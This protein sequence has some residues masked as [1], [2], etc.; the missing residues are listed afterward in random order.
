MPANVPDAYEYDENVRAAVINY[1][2]R[3]GLQPTGKVFGVTL[4]SLN[5]S[6]G[7]RLK[8]MRAILARM[9]QLLP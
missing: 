1:Q 7:Y 2:L 5:A 4:R 8:Q 9:Q 3:N 6:V